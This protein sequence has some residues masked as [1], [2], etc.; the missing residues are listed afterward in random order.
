MWRPVDPSRAGL[1][2]MS[3]VNR[4]AEDE[5]WSEVDRDAGLLQAFTKLESRQK[6]GADAA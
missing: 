4:A 5:I 2:E 6:A 1:D 3:F